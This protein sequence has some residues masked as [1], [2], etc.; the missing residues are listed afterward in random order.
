MFLIYHGFSLLEVQFR[1]VLSYRPG[2]LG[3]N[4]E[5]KISFAPRFIPR[6]EGAFHE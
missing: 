5:S 4:F 2:G 1:L 3:G 6:G